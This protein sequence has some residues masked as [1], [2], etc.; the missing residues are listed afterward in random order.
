MLISFNKDNADSSSMCIIRGL[1]LEY[2]RDR[3]AIDGKNAEGI[4]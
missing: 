1:S 4:R 2:R 3:M